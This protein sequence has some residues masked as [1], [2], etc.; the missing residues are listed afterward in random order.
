MNAAGARQVYVSQA[1]AA[2]V[3]SG[4]LRFEDRGERQFKGVRDHHRVLE[5][6][7]N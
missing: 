7:G 3:V 5:A 4:S 6:L 2:R 1:L